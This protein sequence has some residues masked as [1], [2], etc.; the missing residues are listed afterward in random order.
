MTRLPLAPLLVA[1]STA[2]ALAILAGCS[3]Q[4]PTGPLPD[5]DGAEKSPSSTSLQP[6]P[7]EGPLVP[8]SKTQNKAPAPPAQAL[9]DVLEYVGAFRVPNDEKLGDSTF[10]YGGTAPA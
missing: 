5:P 8:P 7:S 6:P 1:L 10:D 2:S 4:V 3:R 9:T